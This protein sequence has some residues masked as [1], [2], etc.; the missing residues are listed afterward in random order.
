MCQIFGV[1]RSIGLFFKFLFVICKHSYMGKYMNPDTRDENGENFFGAFD[2]VIFY[3]AFSHFCGMDSLIYCIFKRHFFCHCGWIMLSRLTVA[4][5]CKHFKQHV[6]IFIL[7]T[8]CWAALD[9]FNCRTKHSELKGSGLLK[10]GLAGQGPGV[11]CSTVH[12]KC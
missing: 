9:A 2:G 6:V 11:T 12:R 5:V 4:H 7:Q 1:Y 3:D 8:R 10:P